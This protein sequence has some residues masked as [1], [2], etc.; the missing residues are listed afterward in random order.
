[1]APSA[2]HS[3]QKPTAALTTRSTEMIARSAKWRTTAERIA[4]TSIIQG[5]GPQKKRRTRRRGPSRPS[6]RAFAP[7]A[8]RRAAASAV[9][10]PWGAASMTPGA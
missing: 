3:S 9:V 5:M 1:M 7:T 10:S 4:A 6:G 2:C 8:A